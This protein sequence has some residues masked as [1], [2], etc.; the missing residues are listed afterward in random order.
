MVLGLVILSAFVLKD[1]SAIFFTHGYQFFDH[2]M[3]DGGGEVH[4]EL[5]PQFVCRYVLGGLVTLLQI[6]TNVYVAIACGTKVVTSSLDVTETLSA[7][8]DAFFVL[9]IDDALLPFLTFLVQPKGHQFRPKDDS[10]RP[11][12]E[13][14]KVWKYS[15]KVLDSVNILK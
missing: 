9:E 11:D 7:A 3:F 15:F 12:G 13:F 2:Q 10:D 5:W 6:A 4:W 14:G 1:A 8:I